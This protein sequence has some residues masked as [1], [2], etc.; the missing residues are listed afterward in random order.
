MASLH[1]SGGIEVPLPGTFTETVDVELTVVD[2]NGEPA[3]TSVQVTWQ[4]FG[5]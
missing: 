4:C 3:S 5:L 2:C 1:L